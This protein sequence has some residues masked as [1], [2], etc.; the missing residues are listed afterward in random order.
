M[1]EENHFSSH[2]RGDDE[3]E[4]K[5]S[6]FQKN[7]ENISEHFEFENEDKSLASNLKENQPPENQPHK[8]PFLQKIKEKIGHVFPTLSDIFSYHTKKE[9]NVLDR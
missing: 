7:E 1:E 9:L 6:F 8:K 5:K 2:S 4:E 3:E